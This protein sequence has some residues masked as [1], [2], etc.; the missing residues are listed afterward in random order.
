M[1]HTI[2][3]AEGNEGGGWTLNWDAAAWRAMTLKDRTALICHMFLNAMVQDIRQ[4]DVDDCLRHMTKW[5]TDERLK[6]LTPVAW[7]LLPK[8]EQDILT[9]LFI[10]MKGG[11]V[12]DGLGC[13]KAYLVEE[14]KGA[15]PEFRLEVVIDVDRLADK[16]DD[17]MIN[18]ILHEFVHCAYRHSVIEY[19]YGHGSKEQV[20]Q[21][22]PQ[23]NWLIE[24]QAL[25]QSRAWQG[26]AA[27]KGNVQN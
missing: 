13:T 14:D 7:G 1:S 11:P 16:S 8:V 5:V 22:N 17:E 15:A 27:S 10:R 24:V 9:V 20:E 25:F 12:E 23:F 2:V 3:V 4:S 26:A 19:W 21:V 18:T 6:R